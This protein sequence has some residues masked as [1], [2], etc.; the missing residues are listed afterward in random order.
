[1]NGWLVVAYAFVC[2]GGYVWSGMGGT[3][4]LSFWSVSFTSLF[5]FGQF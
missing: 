5:A 1:M 4:L 2:V 3:F